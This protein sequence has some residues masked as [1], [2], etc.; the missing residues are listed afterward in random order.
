MSRLSIWL[1]PPPDRSG[2][3]EDRRYED[4]R[5][6]AAAA[7]PPFCEGG[8][9]GSVSIE[10]NVCLVRHADDSIRQ[11]DENALPDRTGCRALPLRARE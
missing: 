6:C 1:R 5:S 3:Y 7:S 4:R 10:P 11:H 2:D 8:G 9:I